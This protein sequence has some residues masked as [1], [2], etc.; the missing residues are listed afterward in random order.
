MTDS[1]E[2]IFCRVMTSRPLHQ[3]A[4]FEKALYHAQEITRITYVKGDFKRMQTNEGTR[5]EFVN[6]KCLYSTV[7]SDTS[8]S[9]NPDGVTERCSAA[10]QVRWVDN[11]YVVY[12]ENNNHNHSHTLNN[13]TRTSGNK[14]EQLN[15]PS[16]KTITT[17][18]DQDFNNPVSASTMRD[19]IAQ[20]NET[21]DRILSV[22]NRNSYVGI[23]R[24][25]SN[26]V[27][28][29]TLA[30]YEQV[31]VYRQYPE[32][33]LLN[34]AYDVTPTG[35]SLFQFV[36][37]DGFGCAQPVMYS[38]STVQ[39]KEELT[40]L[41]NHFCGIVGNI[42]DTRTFIMDC[43][44]TQTDV[45]QKTFPNARI[46]LN[47]FIIKEAFTRKCD[48]LTAIAFF[49]A[50]I[51]T[52]SSLQFDHYLEKLKMITPNGY[53]YI[54]NTWMPLKKMWATSCCLDAI[55][56]GASVTE[57]IKGANSNIKETLKKLTSVKEIMTIIYN[58]AEKKWTYSN[59]IPSSAGYSIDNRNISEKFKRILGKLTDYAVEMT[60]KRIA[61]IDYVHIDFI[62]EHLALCTDSSFVYEVS[63]DEATCSCP[64]NIS[65]FLP[66][67]HLA[68][69]FI[70]HG[71]HKDLLC[72]SKRWF[73]CNNQ[74]LSK[75]PITIIESSNQSS[76]SLEYKEAVNDT[77]EKL[78]TFQSQQSEQIVLKAAK[79]INVL[80][81]SVL[82]KSSSMNSN[83]K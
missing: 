77:I 49:H 69:V 29:I 55:T 17:G 51:T 46:L 11:C 65:S 24:N 63:R 10:F 36:V 73:Q 58:E 32:V 4:D 2:K 56:L 3:W 79:Q 53:N 31:D 9:N 37:T 40:I 20:S 50:M 72:K 45:V 67:E 61:R 30:R 41:L 34:A 75:P 60:W 57:I 80:L 6:Y 62:N 15:P 52:Q 66:C 28:Q 26:K 71:L 13:R 38:I 54:M 78:K 5:Y 12:F 1:A 42:S 25:S 27:T 81:E 19:Q 18:H 43:A 33:V 39:Q 74:N 23:E 70:V 48:S 64:F 16:H 76:V 82:A 14:K 83:N 59:S 68:K 44:I 7:S 22:I 47:P 21:L 8:N 35:F